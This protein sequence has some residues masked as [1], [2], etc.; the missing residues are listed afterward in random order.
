MG[1]TATTTCVSLSWAMLNSGKVWWKG[2][3]ESEY[4]VSDI[5]AVELR[6]DPFCDSGVVFVIGTL[7]LS[8]GFRM[9]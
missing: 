9:F 8:I 5:L 7:F 4:E 2:M 1:N 3:D 6:E